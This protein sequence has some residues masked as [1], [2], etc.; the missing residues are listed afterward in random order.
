MGDRFIS[1]SYELDLWGGLLPHFFGVKIKDEDKTL[2]TWNFILKFFGSFLVDLTKKIFYPS[3]ARSLD[4]GYLY[5]SQLKNGQNG[6]FLEK[7]VPMDGFF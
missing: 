7:K 1:W 4:I 6:V 3:A 2:T 5:G